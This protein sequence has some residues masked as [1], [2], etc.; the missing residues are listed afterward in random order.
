MIRRGRIVV[1]GDE[2]LEI[3]A[4]AAGIDAYVFDDDCKKLLEWLVAN[5]ESY[6]VIVYL[7]IVADKC[8]DVKE[9]FERG[10]REKMVLPIGHPMKGV[11]RSPKDYYR[12]ITKKVLGMEVSL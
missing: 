6:D 12:E 11:Y 10:V 1:I 7:D 4:L 2:Y 3:V 8:R 9:L 5:I